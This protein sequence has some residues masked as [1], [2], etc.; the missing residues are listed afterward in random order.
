[1]IIVV[2]CRKLGS[3]S[4]LL[5]AWLAG[6]LP[7]LRDVCQCVFLPGPP[8]LA[9][10]RRSGA[11]RALRGNE[12]HARP[13]WPGEGTAAPL[14]RW[15]RRGRASGRGRKQRRRPEARAR[16]PRTTGPA[17]LAKAG[18]AG[19]G[20]DAAAPARDDPAARHERGLHCGCRSWA[21]EAWTSGP[22][23]LGTPGPGG[24]GASESPAGGTT[25]GPRGV[26][27]RRGALPPASHH[28]ASPAAASAL[29]AGAWLRRARDSLS[30]SQ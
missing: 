4:H 29:F 28:A 18:R 15:W 21:Q 27:K 20:V 25:G 10:R 26:A 23:G 12:P 8:G 22:G 19:G 11:P 5:S 9:A 16:E 24:L 13:L 7:A 30:A 3:R 17:R 6:W 2:S 14:A 1:M